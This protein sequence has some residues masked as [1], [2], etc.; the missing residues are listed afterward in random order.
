MAERELLDRL[1]LRVRPRVDPGYRPPLR[2]LVDGLW[3]IDRRLR[4]F[5]SFI[6]T[7]TT[8]ARLDSGGL[9]VISAPPEPRK[10]AD[11]L[12][13]LGELVGV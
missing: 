10:S 1:F 8:V 3:A 5:G 7:R 9:V 12:R 2:P 4:A 11:E 6:E 13:G